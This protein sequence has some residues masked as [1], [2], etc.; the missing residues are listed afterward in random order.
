[1]LRKPRPDHLA[2]QGCDSVPLSVRTVNTKLN[3]LP[4]NEISPKVL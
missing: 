4:K 1:M 2:K 3:H